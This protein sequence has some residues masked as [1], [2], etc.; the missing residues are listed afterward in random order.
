MDCLRS[1]HGSY[2]ALSNSFEIYLHNKTVNRLYN[3]SQ[4]WNVLLSM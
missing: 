3:L 1:D 4:S 2:V